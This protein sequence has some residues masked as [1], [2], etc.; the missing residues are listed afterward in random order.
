MGLVWLAPVFTIP[1]QKRGKRSS[2][3]GN[4]GAARSTLPGPVSIQV[5]MKRDDR[6]VRNSICGFPFEKYTTK[7]STIYIVSIAV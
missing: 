5:S 3:N 7:E 6:T 4:V 2:G 1:D